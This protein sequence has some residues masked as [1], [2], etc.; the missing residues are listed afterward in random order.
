MTQLLG[1]SLAHCLYKYIQYLAC[2]IIVPIRTPY[3]IE[4]ESCYETKEHL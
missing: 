2:I 3:G 4:D 1:V